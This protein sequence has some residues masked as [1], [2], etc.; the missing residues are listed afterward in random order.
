MNLG[1]IARALGL[2]VAGTSLWLFG[3]AAFAAPAPDGSYQQSCRNI[4]AS[5]GTLT[6]ECHTRSGRWAQSTLDDYRNCDGDISN[7]NGKLRCDSDSDARGDGQNAGAP[8][9]D[10]RSWRERDNDN[11]NDD[12]DRDHE[13][14]WQTP[15]G[16]YRDSCRNAHVEGDALIAE[17]RNRDGDWHRTTLDDYR[18]C[19]DDIMNDDGRLRCEGDHGYRHDRDRRD[20]NDRHDG[21]WRPRGSYQDTCRHIRVEDG[22]LSAYCRTRSGKWRSTTLD[23]VREC[24]GDISN[25]NGNLVCRRG[26]R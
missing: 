10:D 25:D 16:S 19:G 6:A 23:D 1:T 14:T 22:D 15:R 11:A 9:P 20:D 5:R 21:D 18:R 26:R 24:R 17:C 8:P 4:N 13:H 2:C 7:D 3:G 12:A